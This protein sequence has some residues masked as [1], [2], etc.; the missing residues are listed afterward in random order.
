MPVVVIASP[1]GGSGKSTTAVILGTELAARDIP[2]VMAD[3]DPNKCLTIWAE[4][5]PL[6]KRITLLEGITEATI[7]RR[8]QDE[9]KDGRIV[10]CDLEGVASRMTTRAISEADLVLTPM[11]ATSL[12]AEIGVRAIQLVQEE[13]EMLRRPIRQAIVF[14]MT[15]GVRSRMHMDL[16]A[17]FEKQ[18]VTV[19]QPSLMER[20]PYAALFAIGGDLR[21][22]PTVGQNQKKAEASKQGALENAEH[23]TRAILELL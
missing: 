8:L 16:E 20:T 1:K 10:I 6:P 17:S 23:F 5:A 11:R 12:D 22:M 7:V 9:D 21:S 4:K 19:V 18:G 3:L 2:V 14:T 15:K 13:E